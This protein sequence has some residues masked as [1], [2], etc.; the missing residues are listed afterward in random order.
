MTRNDKRENH[1]KILTMSGEIIYFESFT[2]DLGRHRLFQGGQPVKLGA[3]ALDLLIYLAR[4]PSELISKNELLDSVWGETVV[5]ENA[6]A[7]AL[8]E[9]RTALG[10]D[11]RNPR[12]IE[13]V[14]RRGFRFV[15]NITPGDQD[16]LVIAVL[17]LVNTSGNP[18]NT[19]LSDALTLELINR[20]AK[21]D[22]LRLRVI[23]SS[24][25][26]HFAG[27]SRSADDIASELKADYVLSGGQLESADT[28][29]LSL[30]LDRIS[31]HTQV[32][33]R[34]FEQPWPALPMVQNIIAQQV[35]DALA[36]ELIEERGRL[37]ASPAAYSEYAKGNYL[38]RNWTEFG[39]SR[40]L[41]HY[42]TAIALDPEYAEAHAGLANAHGTLAY[43]GLLHPRQAREQC[44]KYGRRALELDPE[45]TAA[46]VAL[47]MAHLYLERDFKRARQYLDIADQSYPQDSTTTLA[48]INLNWAQG[49]WQSSLARAR[50]VLVNDPLSP[51]LRTVV[52][53]SLYLGRQYSAAIEAGDEA[54]WVNEQF[55]TAHAVR[56]TSLVQL[57]KWK[58]A[59]EAAARAR[60]YSSDQPAMIALEGFVE[61]MSGNAEAAQS[62]L[63]ELEALQAERTVSPTHKA[64]V[65]I[66]LGQLE[67][68]LAQ[69]QLA[70]QDGFP[71]LLFLDVD[72][73]YD[74]LREVPGFSEI[75]TPSPNSEP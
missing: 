72:P 11:A 6:I 36:L 61:G 17:P 65:L 75:S 58:P 33:S 18:D 55:P 42:E 14:A 8:K 63:R 2:L 13:T 70:L 20:L 45:S 47:G 19:Y 68:A 27:S 25:S 38:F 71:D 41:R 21:I 66:G 3:R 4:N 74:R 43:W 52:A 23:G 48:L 50:T 22:P 24:S 57:A 35:A 60:Q 49:K 28:L 30:A 40:A 39:F 44:F 64:W 15:A 9:L 54:L 69:L 67:A 29:T 46:L 73:M 10:D 32:W 59:R 51:I 53:Q 37:T 1:G 5:T 31:D 34:R 7:R 26:F 56:A 62:S 16:R 12:F